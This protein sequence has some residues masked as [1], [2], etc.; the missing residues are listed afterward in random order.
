MNNG[1]CANSNKMCMVTQYAPAPPAVAHLQSIAYTPVVPSAMNIHDR[2]AAAC[3][4]R[5]HRDWS[6]QNTPCSDLNSQPKW[7]GDLNILTLKV[8]SK[9]RVTWAGLSVL[10]LG[11]MYTTYVRQKHC[12][13]PPCIRDISSNVKKHAIKL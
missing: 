2:L 3:S 1:T 9:S 8:V 10:N 4:G 5:W 6:R 12:L 13:M 11:P 7:P